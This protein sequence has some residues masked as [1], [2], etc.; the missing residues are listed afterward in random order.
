MKWLESERALEE[1]K[2]SL[3]RANDENM[4]LANLLA[5]KEGDINELK[6]MV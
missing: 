1:M 6:E 4:I 2:A 5:E 3:L